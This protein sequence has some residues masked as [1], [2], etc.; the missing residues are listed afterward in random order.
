MPAYSLTTKNG[1]SHITFTRPE[2]SN[3]MGQ[4]FWSSFGD[5]IRK[6]NEAGETRV[7]VVSAE[8]KNFCAGMELSAFSAGIAKTDTPEEREAFSHMVRYLQDT[9]S[10]VEKARF[11]V[12]A[13]VQGAC[14]GAGLDF[15][16]ACDLVVASEDAYFR[17]EEINIGMMAD[18]GSLQRL[19]KLIPERVVRE[20]AYLGSTLNAKDSKDLGLINDVC[21]DKDAALNRAMEMAD[22]ISKKAP[23]AI[24]GS[25]R[26]ITYARDHSTEDALEWAT[27]AQAGY[28]KPSD[29][30]QAVQARMTKTDPNFEDPAPINTSFLKPSK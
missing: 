19:P 12:I 1:I 2:V 23:I 11:P 6:L 10:S 25:K 13:A 24:A 3:A 29:I 8:G 15:I 30:M 7:L 26:S 5:T 17:I 18:V 27:V 20:L 21:T 9:L 14:I 4:E 16:A 22:I 28:W